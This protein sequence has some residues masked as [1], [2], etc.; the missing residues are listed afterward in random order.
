MKKVFF[1]I[2][3]L[4]IS[5]SAVAQTTSLSEEESEQAKIRAAEKVGIFTGYLKNIGEKTESLEYRLYYC[6]EA[7]NL[8]VGRGDDYT[9]TYYEDNGNRR[10][11][12]RKG[13]QMQVTSVNG[14]KKNSY[15][16]KNYL[17]NLAKLNYSQVEIETT[18]VAHIKVSNLYKVGDN[19]YKCT[20]FFKQAFIGYRDSKPVYKDI[21]EKKVDCYLIIEDILGGTEY[22]VQLGDVT[23]LETQSIDSKKS[24]KDVL[25]ILNQ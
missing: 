7:L 5:I 18:D 22:M 6:K 1:A 17:T 24:V 13:V 16:L 8:F 9:E 4:A 15:L 12:E 21:T 2:L 20:C 19:T 3:S 10:I 23:A 25:D 11:V 14:N